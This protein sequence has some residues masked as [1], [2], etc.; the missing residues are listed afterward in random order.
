M[1][2]PQVGAERE[3]RG[4]G[5]ALARVL[6]SRWWLIGVLLL[7]TVLR[8]GYLHELGATPWFDHLVVDPEYYDAWARRIAAGDW[9]GTGAFYM[10]PLYPYLLG[11][12]YAVAG[13]GLWLPRL[14]NV[15]FSVATCAVVAVLGRRVAGPAVGGL[16]ALG[17]ALYEPDVFFA[18]EIDKT[19]L[20]MLLVVATLALGLRPTLAAR[21]GTGILLGLAVLT[22]ANLLVF[23]PLGVLLALRDQKTRA[24]G[25]LLFLAGFAVVI[26]PVTWRNHRVAG[27]WV[28][29]TTQLGQ[30]FYTGNNPENPYGAYGVVSFVRANPHFEEQDFHAAAEARAGRPLTTAATSWFWFRAALDHMRTDPAFALRAFGRK[31]MLLWNDFEIS[32]SQDQYL[33]ERYSRVLRLPL[34]GFGEVFALAVLG[35]F[36]CF[37]SH[38]AVPLLVGFIVIYGAT[39]VAFF[40]FARY[41]VQLVPA[42]LPLAALGVGAL[43]ERVRDREP[44]RLLTA[45]AVVAA[46]GWMSFHTVGIFDRDHPNVVEMRL[47]HLADVE[48]DVGHSDLAIA[49]LQEA[50]PNCIYGCPW[51]L[52][53]LFAVYQRT[54]RFE[55]G[56][57]YFERFVREHPEQRDAPQYLADLRARV[58][59]SK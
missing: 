55:E 44:R 59:A 45:V 39:L 23:A 15:G 49:A 28:L 12:L 57:L 18:G 17:L 47:R 21:A 58:P 20:S 40:L 52:A 43:I 54:G 7:A 31:T 22:R 19:S 2:I 10:D 8:L 46:A 3:A 24:A 16:A 25:A 11:G 27:E 5:D 42:L 30:N 1:P 35:T 53:D 51:A 14:V 6:A 9:L 33:L 29:T 56:T 38:R 32:D 41:R 50:V 13:H 4:M 48:M 34:L 37:R 36:V 26:A